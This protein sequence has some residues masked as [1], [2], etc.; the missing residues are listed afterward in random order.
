[1]VKAVLAPGSIEAQFIKRVRQGHDAGLVKKVLTP[2][3]TDILHVCLCMDGG[4]SNCAASVFVGF[5]QLFNWWGGSVQ[6]EI[7]SFAFVCAADP[8]QEVAM[9]HLRTQ[10]TYSTSVAFGR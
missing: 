9:M 8:A 2:V 10:Q 6:I 7:S 3:G 4:V 5:Q 1:M